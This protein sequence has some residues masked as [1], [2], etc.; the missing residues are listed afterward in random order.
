MLANPGGSQGI[1]ALGDRSAL[2]RAAYRN[3]EWAGNKIGTWAKRK[4]E[5]RN[6]RD[7][8]TSARRQK[9]KPFSLTGYQ[10]DGNGD[11][12][13]SFTTYG[14]RAPRWVRDNMKRYGVGHVFR[15]TGDAYTCASNQQNIAP[16]GNYLDATDVLNL[17]NSVGLGA[18]GY[19]ASKLLLLDVHS[20]SMITNACNSHIHATVYDVVARLDGFTTVNAGP[21]TAFTLGFADGDTGA[22]ADYLVPGATPYNNPRFTA[23]YKIIK[24]TELVLKAGQTHVHTV[25]YNVNR[26]VSKERITLNGVGPIAGL[27]VYSVVVFHGTPYHDAATELVVGTAP[28]KIDTVKKDTLRYC[29]QQLSFPVIDYVNNLSTVTAGEQWVEN[30]PLDTTITS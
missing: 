6:K 20:E 18:A 26:V 4:W 29:M 10:I 15:V 3:V 21:V 12:T 14:K 9:P 8:K 11:E 25:R 17:F 1:Y 28:V 24:R 23:A 22:A 7:S 13:K 30:T 27:S 16:I 5:Q 2:R 19:A